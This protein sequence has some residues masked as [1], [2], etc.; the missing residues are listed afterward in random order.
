ML[1]NGLDFLCKMNNKI[2]RLKI[3][4]Y[5]LLLLSIHPASSFAQILNDVTIPDTTKQ[6]T[7]VVK[8]DSISIKI[9]P[10]II[11]D[12]TTFQQF[13]KSP[14]QMPESTMS[15]YFHEDIGDLLNYFPG[16]YLMDLGSSGQRLGWNRHGANDKQTTLFFDGRPFYDPIYGGIDLNLVPVGFTKTITV[17]QGL[18]SHFI[19]SAAEVISLKSEGYNEDIPHSLVGYHKAPYGFSDIDIV[20]GQRISKKINLLL[21]GIIK[22][23][24][25]KTDSYSFE[26]QNFRGKVD[27]QLTPSWQFAYSWIS[28]KINR[29]IPDPILAD[30]S[31]QLTDATQQVSRLDQTL[32]ISGRIFNSEF[33]NFQANIFYSSLSDKLK[34][35][36]FDLQYSD[37]GRYAGFNLQTQHR[38]LKQRI[39]PGAQF[40]HQWTDA[41]QVG[42]NKHSYGSIFI[43]DDWEWTEQL[44]IRILTN[45]QFHNIHGSQISGGL[46]SYCSLLKNTKITASARQ[47]I[48]Y[49]TFFELNART[50]FVGNPDLLPESHQKIELTLDWEV[51]PKFSLT[52]ALYYKNVQHTIY[53]H[54]LDSS[55]VAFLNGKELHYAGFDVQFRWAI[56]SRLRL[57]TLFGAIDNS[58]LLDQPEMVFAGYLE[59]N[60]GFFQN[61]VRPT[62]RLEGR[63]FGAR[64]S[65]VAHPYF[66]K[67]YQQN[68]N[69][70]F[71]LNAHAI[72]DFG[73]LKVF[74]TLENMFD[75]AYQ[76]TYGYPMNERTLH[77]GL[78]WEFW[79]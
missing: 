55:Q 61:D 72:L 33:R 76:L 26:Q 49:P 63:Y 15:Q 79:N 20:F 70:V 69:P 45:Y 6:D 40:I 12:D 62:L 36:N 74:I 47:S 35:K 38:F 59:Y 52:S 73:N 43:Q 75:K 56:L 77:Y 21:G 78:R 7:V 28:N 31:Y 64:N 65:L 51:K 2:T 54:P 22:S 18:S 71:I 29:H 58:S 11:T 48:R 17:E 25:G 57:N 3:S 44:G 32:N 41:D 19:T 8:P 16:I 13:M 23:Y 68:L 39:T 60:D 9:P 37:F 5:I 24:D 10:K 27:Y 4:L 14:W 50:N 30:A 67:A 46:S 1:F 42:N 53:L 66:Y 34:D